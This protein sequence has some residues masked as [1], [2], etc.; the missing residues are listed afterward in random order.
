[1]Q[2]ATP[3]SSLTPRDLMHA[4][5]R[6][7]SGSVPLLSIEITRECPLSCP[8]CYAY[9]DTHLGGGVT[10]SELRDFRGDALVEGVLDLVRRHRP[11]HV[12]LVGGEPMIRHREL[13][14]I[15]PALSEMGIFSMVVTS[16]VIPIPAHWMDI[17]RMRVA[18][19][20]DGLPEH[21]DIRRKPATYERILTNIAGRK[22]NVH[23][24]I[25]RPMLNRP[26][27]LEDYVAFWN[28]RP[29]VDHIWVSLYSPQMGEESP[30]RLK[31]EDRERVARE[32][33][34][35]RA[36]YPKLLIPEGVA[37]A[38]VEP[39]ENPQNCLFSKLSINYSA[40]LQSRV[41]PCVFGGTPDCTQCGCSISSALHW[42]QS[43]RIVGPLRV[44][45]V[46]T[47]SLNVG[48]AMNRLRRGRR[49][50]DRWQPGPRS[51]G[52]TV[53]LVQI[54]SIE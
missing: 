39:P 7:L 34:P 10:L 13:D 26:N 25:T 22:I 45:H 21:H 31:P 14:R 28:E 44:G 18:V 16:G 32:L 49:P 24:V 36:R 6:I 52:T 17:P 40:D 54:E 1:M 2:S 50:P 35:L 27:Y 11:M 48:S 4:W 9:G 53:P 41:E 38:F 29:E 8:G 5:A 51:S 19:S 30:E 23:W 46:V 43:E 3:P 12:S 33:P 20:V 47:A 37:R 42:I 15:L